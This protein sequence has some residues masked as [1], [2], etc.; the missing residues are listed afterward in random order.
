A[1]H[2][3]D[4]ENGRVSALLEKLELKHTSSSRKSSVNTMDKMISKEILMHHRMP[5][6]MAKF[7]TD[8]VVAEEEISIHVADKPT[9]GGSS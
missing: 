4:G 9:R 7:L 2:G 8:K 1:L 5:T 3:E 6:T